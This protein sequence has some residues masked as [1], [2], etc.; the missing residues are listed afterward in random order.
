M[1]L[2]ERALAAAELI[3]NTNKTLYEELVAIV[4]EHGGFIDTRA[5]E[6]KP[7]LFDINNTGNLGE[8]S[9][10]TPIHGIRYVEGEGLFILTDTELDNY[11]Y[12]TGCQFEYYFNFEGEDATHLDDAMKDVTYFR[13]LDDGYTDVTATVS[14]IMSN[15]AQYL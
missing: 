5:C 1:T 7:V 6:E 13:N 3:Y 11:A 15:L 2:K 10:A 14:S 9:Q 12:D 8:C 4:K